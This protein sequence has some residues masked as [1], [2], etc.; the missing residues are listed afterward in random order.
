MGYIISADELAQELH[1]S[2]RTIVN[3]RAGQ[4]NAEILRGLPEPI[5]RKP[6]RWLRSDIERWLESRSTFRPTETAPPPLPRRG[7]G[8]PRKLQA[9]V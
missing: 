9:Q 8:R 7:P 3:F 6:L 2:R 4:S 1:I 5:H